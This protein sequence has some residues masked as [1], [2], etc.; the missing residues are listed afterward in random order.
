M[1][2]GST[3]SGPYNGS[4]SLMKSTRK[5]SFFLIKGSQASSFNAPLFPPLLSWTTITDFSWSILRNASVQHW[6]ITEL[7]K[8]VSTEKTMGKKIS[9][10]DRI[11]YFSEVLHSSLF[12]NSSIIIRHITVIIFVFAVPITIHTCQLCKTDSLV[13]YLL[14]P[15]CSE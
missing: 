11:T 5:P 8:G 12:S 14:S 9:I 10:T 3:W 4:Q 7:C 2:I 15:H 1:A 13:S 6:L